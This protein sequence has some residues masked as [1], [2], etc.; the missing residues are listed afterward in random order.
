MAVNPCV[1]KF[2]KKEKLQGPVAKAMIR[3]LQVEPDKLALKNQGIYLLVKKETAAE[4]GRR[5]P[6]T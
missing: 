4:A 3:T 6:L 1:P 2:N 5:K